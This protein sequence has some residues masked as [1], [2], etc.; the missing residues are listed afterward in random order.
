ML[1]ATLAFL[2]RPLY[3][4]ISKPYHFRHKA[5]DHI[6]VAMRVACQAGILYVPDDFRC[7]LKNPKVFL[8]VGILGVR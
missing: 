4:T 7:F 1:A 6:D 8:G 5:L 3:G 2:P